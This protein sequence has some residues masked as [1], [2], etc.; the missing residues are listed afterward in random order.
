[1]TAS[2]PKKN[3]QPKQLSISPI[4]PSD[5]EATSEETFFPIFPG[6]RSDGTGFMD[7]RYI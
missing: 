4:P 5:S 6:V 7:G 1:M 2:I 3:L